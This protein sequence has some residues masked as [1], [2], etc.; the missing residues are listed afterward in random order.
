MV[1][2][3]SNSTWTA[4]P[5]WRL[6]GCGLV[7]AIIILV[8]LLNGPTA[9]AQTVICIGQG[10]LPPQPPVVQLVPSNIATYTIRLCS[11][12][13]LQTVVV[14]PILSPTGK[15]VV[16]PASLIYTTKQGQV[17]N[18]SQINPQ[19]TDPFTV[20]I[21][22]DAASDDPSYDLG[23]ELNPKVLAVFNPPL[24]VN[25][26]AATQPGLAVTITVLANDLDRSHSGLVVLSV[27]TPAHGSATL[28]PDQTVTYKPNAQ[29]A[30]TD[31][32]S[33]TI[34]DG[35]GNQNTGMISVIV[36]PPNYGEPEVRHIVLSGS[37]TFVFTDSASSPEDTVDLTTTVGLPAGF[38]TGTGNAKDAF[39]LIFS[40]VISP[41][42]D[43]N[44]PPSS[45][46]YANLAFSLVAYLNNIKLSGIMLVQPVT[47]TVE[48]SNNAIGGI[49]ESTLTPYY[50]NGRAWSRAGIAAIR[51]NPDLNR[52][53]FTI[54]RTVDELAF[55]GRLP[56]IYLP[57]VSR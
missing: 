22:H 44:D 39:V 18:V 1:R 57:Y 9:S 16:A 51:R 4:S 3:A 13:P 26:T 19:T 32:F 48:Y 50:W 53:G 24:A 49:V 2:M 6:V 43:V 55:F 37:S 21:S 42:A 41:T 33:Y 40:P 14:T 29:F 52:L 5:V 15:I 54:D 20:T 34:E 46:T 47:L 8:G 10:T 38:I 36:N 45:N 28:N 27:S 30:G 17:V 31:A 35:N 7:G 25:D 23:P 12:P 11:D 56:T